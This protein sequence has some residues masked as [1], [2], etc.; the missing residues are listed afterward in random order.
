MSSD[1]LETL[2]WLCRREAE[3]SIPPD[4]VYTSRVYDGM[5]DED[6]RRIR[7]IRSLRK[8]GASASTPPFVGLLAEEMTAATRAEIAE[9]IAGSLAQ[10]DA[11]AA[12]L[13]TAKDDWERRHIK[14]Q[15]DQ[16]NSVIDEYARRREWYR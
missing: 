6:A 1:E 12:K 10:R 4:D 14:E 8:L 7:L 16:S 9:A 5:K 2:K 11:N 13:K 3:R 15:I